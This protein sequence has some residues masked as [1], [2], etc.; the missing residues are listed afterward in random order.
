MQLPPGRDFSGLLVDVEEPDLVV[1]ADGDDG[2]ARHW[3]EEGGADGLAVAD[4][5]RHRRQRLGLG[6]RTKRRKVVEVGLPGLC[7]VFI[8]VSVH[9]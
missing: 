4:Q 1:V 8:F 9:N 7:F 2:L 5:R 3:R 6:S